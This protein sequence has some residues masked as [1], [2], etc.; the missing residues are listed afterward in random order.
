MKRFAQSSVNYSTCLFL[1]CIVVSSNQ[2]VSGAVRPTV[3]MKLGRT[4]VYVGESAGLTVTVAAPKESP[5][6]ILITRRSGRELVRD[7]Q[8]LLKSIGFD[9][10]EL[11]GWIGRNTGSAIERFQES[12]G[13]Q[14]TGTMSDELVRQLYGAVGIDSPPTGHI[15]VRQDFTP[16]F[17]APVAIADSEIPLG[18]HLFTL[19]DSENNPTETRWL[20]TTLDQGMSDFLFRAWK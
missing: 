13:L 12:R 4:K 7:V 18:N 3:E 1:F 19:I 16:V 11:D 5:V 20:V 9:P 2:T 8:T 6:R 10:G 17:D 15:Y 14:K